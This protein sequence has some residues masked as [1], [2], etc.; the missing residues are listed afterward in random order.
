[1][2]RVYKYENR[3]NRINLDCR[4]KV[5]RDTSLEY[6]RKGNDAMNDGNK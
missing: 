1:M 5:A 2:F 3:S 4:L 6:I